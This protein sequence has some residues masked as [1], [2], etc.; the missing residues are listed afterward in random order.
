VKVFENRVAVVTGAASGIGR[1]LAERFAAANMKIVL[2]D[3]EQPVLETTAQTMR[4]T[5]ATVAA[6]VADV[7]QA[8][9]VER[10]ADFAYETFGAVHILCNNAGVAG[11]AAPAWEQSLETWRWILG[12]NLWGVLHGVHAFVPRMLAGGEE[13]HIVN[14]A[15]VAGL[16]TG[17]FLSPYYASKHAVVA[18]SES[19]N[20]DLQLAGAKLQA[21]VLCPAFAKTRIAESGRNQPAAVSSGE[22][23]EGMRQRVEVG[24]PPELIAEKVWEAVRDN[25]FWVL[26]HPETDHLIRDRCE[27]ML[28]RRNPVPHVFTAK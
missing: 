7:S 11:G 26:T 17:P 23:P 5:G 3:V 12:V 1:A 20:F 27:E 28:Q 22:F 24:M 4:E 14:T 13:G 10:L 25:Q 21:S 16:R 15:S 9:D 8:A 2:A 18:L 19:L 6:C